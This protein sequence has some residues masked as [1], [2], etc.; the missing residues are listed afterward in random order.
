MVKH[1]VIVESPTKARTLKRFLGPD[2][3]V[4][5]S[6]GHIRDLPA[7]AAE[8]PARYKG[9]AWARLGV[10]VERDF[11]PLYVVLPA[12]KKKIAELKKLLA[13]ADVLLLATD[14]DREG[15]AISWHL[16]EVLQPT[17]P[18]RRMVFHEITK[19]AV[20]AALESTREIDQDLVHAQEARRIIDRLYGYEVSPVLWRKIG[21]RLSAGR[22]QSVA[23]RI[24]V[25]R[26][27]ARMRFTPAE[28]WDLEA[29]F[30]A[31]GGKLFTARLLSLD[32]RRIAGG[33]DFDPDTGELRRADVERLDRER[34]QALHAA[35][36]RE[37]FRVV[38]AEEKP[39]SRAPAPPFTTSTLQQEGNRK[40]R[41]DASRTMR[42]AQRLYENGF[43]TY[44]RTDSVALSETAIRL[45]RDAIRRT[46]GEELLSPE[47]RRYFQ[48]VKNAQEAHEA[49]RPA[50]DEIAPV[51]AIRRKLGADEA[52]IYELI[53][54]RTLACQMANARGRRLTVQVANGGGAPAA[55]FQAAGNAIDFPGFLRAYAED[56]DDAEPSA[57]GE[58]VLPPLAAGD[59]VRVAEL[60]AA[61]HVT[62]PPPRLTEAALVK[63]L[64]ESGI[65]RPSTY[66]SI[67]DTIERREYT[68]RKG[69]ALVPTF[70]AFAVVA[71]MEEH[72]SHLIDLEFTARMEERLDAISRG[73]DQTL[74]YLRDFYQGNGEPGLRP[75]LDQKTKDIDPRAVCSI[76]VGTDD[77]GREI[78]VRV[79][80]YGPFLQRGESTAPLPDL[81]CPDEVTPAFAGALL[82]AREKGDEPIGT[83]PDT[84][85]PIFVKAGRYG[86]YVQLGAATDG[87]KPKMV[88]LLRGMEPESLSLATAVALLSL[89]RVLGQDAEGHDVVAH[90]GR[91]GPTGK[92]GADTRSLSPADDLLTIDLARALALLAEEKRRGGRRSVSPLKDF[93]SVP[94]LEGA[95]VRILG[96]RYGPYVTDGSTNASLPKTIEDPASITL[97]QALELLAAQRGKKGSARRG[98]PAARRRAA[99]PAPAGKKPPAAKATKKLPAARAAKQKKHA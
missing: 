22:V 81:T 18:V 36:G 51:E 13:A 90:P 23:V 53:W 6:I 25:D 43:I 78:I 33:K 91:D 80:R 8:V 85:E 71:L 31:P 50:G 20:L 28:Y 86:P 64:E 92:R 24:L 77:A 14:E 45:T 59:A 11:A 62:T 9:T 12:K 3:V 27:R 75:L 34:A 5:S 57:P 61:E 15:E 93:G 94:A 68:F 69:T 19:P 39:F 38:S 46:Y 73:E 40:L 96:G 82:A 44:M 72:L 4:E 48:K 7:N 10:N 84:G 30:R 63:A 52:R 88:S 35:L 37:S 58:A 67:I 83:H 66:A 32:G 42:A 21:S 49:I 17:I 2:Y 79:G 70:T 87:K 41:F 26:E 47:P 55:V 56:A 89:P 65:G 60:R 99:R 1:L 16:G 74:P 76:P 95:E 54:K 98:G 97:E 29:S